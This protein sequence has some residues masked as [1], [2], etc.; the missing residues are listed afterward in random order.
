MSLVK[1]GY[2]R[3]SKKEREKHERMM[4]D[5]HKNT[6]DDIGSWSVQDIVL[7]LSFLEKRLEESAPTLGQ[8]KFKALVIS[9]RLYLRLVDVQ[10]EFGLGGGE[11]DSSLSSVCDN[12]YSSMEEQQTIPRM[13][14]C[15]SQLIDLWTNDAQLKN[16]L[17]RENY[18]AFLL[19]KLLDSDTS[20]LR[21]RSAASIRTQLK[22]ALG[23]SSS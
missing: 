6:L 2:S 20:M 9:L 22:Q 18:S 16:D 4:S 5:D 12:G 11:G 17:L 14:T 21:K 1:K 19:V 23:I 15:L 8:V 7:C 10:K 13:R 3:L